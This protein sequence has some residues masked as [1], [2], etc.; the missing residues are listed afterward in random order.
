MRIRAIKM[1]DIADKAIAQELKDQ[2]LEEMF[3]YIEQYAKAGRYRL[4]INSDLSIHGITNRV[5]LNLREC[6]PYVA[7][8]L[9]LEGYHVEVTYRT[10]APYFN[11]VYVSW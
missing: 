3:G 6:I 8:V 4:V 2:A 11:R 5:S 7:H 9:M 1:H 10:D